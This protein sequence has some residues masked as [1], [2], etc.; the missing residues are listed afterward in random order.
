LPR[1]LAGWDLCLLPFA[2]NESTRFISP[3]KTLEYMAA[4]LPIIG[5]DI[6]DVIE[7]YGKAVS[8]AR[9]QDE[10]IAACE[11]ALSADPQQKAEIIVEMRTL[12]AASSWEQ[13][14]EQMRCL[15]SDV[16]IR[17]AGSKREEKVSLPPE[18]ASANVKDSATGANEAR[19]PVLTVKRLLL[20]EKRSQNKG[21]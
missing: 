19:L 3:T 15:L 8:I 18:E 4:E 20:K 13:T 2:H 12:V 7:L 5:T 21:L 6:A 10:F 9:N 16:T 11:H 14:A 17:K 1:F